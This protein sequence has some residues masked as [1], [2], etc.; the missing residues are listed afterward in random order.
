MCRAGNGPASGMEISGEANSGVSAGAQRAVARRLL[1][2]PERAVDVTAHYNR[3]DREAGEPAPCHSLQA[4]DAGSD[5][6]ASQLKQSATPDDRQCPAEGS[7]DPVDRHVVRLDG[8]GKETEGEDLQRRRGLLRV[9]LPEYSE[10]RLGTAQ[11]SEVRQSTKG[12][13]DR[14]GEA[15]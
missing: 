12:N 7:P 4:A 14:E 3:L 15:K 5:R 8:Q 13:R 6:P 1:P 9:A 10:D 2:P 11:K